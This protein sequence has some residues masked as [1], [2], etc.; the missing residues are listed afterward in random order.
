MAIASATLALIGAIAG[1]VGAASAAGTGA[2]SIVEANEQKKEGKDAAARQRAEQER[3]IKE[4]QQ[5]EADAATLEKATMQRDQ[6]RQG[7]KTKAAAAGGR[8][9]TILTSPLGLPGDLGS[10]GKTILGS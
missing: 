6:L 7:Q 2:Y 4:K 1:V 8:A 9:G 3:L 10:G 5:K